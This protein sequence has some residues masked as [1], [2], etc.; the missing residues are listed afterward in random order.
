M[1]IWQVLYEI[2]GDP[3][4]WD[5]PRDT[6]AKL[7]IVAPT[8]GAVEFSHTYTDRWYQPS[9]SVVAEDGTFVSKYM[10]RPAEYC[11]TNISNERKRPMR[12]IAILN[13]RPGEE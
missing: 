7:E 13:Q 1:A 12:R 10:L 6:S 8:C 4:W 2:H 11:Q 5:Y 9:G 3:Y